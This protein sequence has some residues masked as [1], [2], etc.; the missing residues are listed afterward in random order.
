MG[1]FYLQALSTPWYVAGEH[2]SNG[3]HSIYYR[4][5]F[6]GDSKIIGIEKRF[7]RT[8]DNQIIVGSGSIIGT[9]DV[10]PQ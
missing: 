10:K 5:M 8:A 7:T 1:K 9:A 6:Q 4:E 2:E 3:R